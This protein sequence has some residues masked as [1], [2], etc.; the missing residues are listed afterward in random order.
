MARTGGEKTRCSGMWTEAKFKSFIKGNLR[1]TTMK[2]APISQCL[3]EARVERGLYLCAG[4]KEH[5]PATVKEGRV[6]KKFVHVDHIEPIIDPEE[7]WVSWDETIDSMFCELDNLQ[8]LCT[9]CHDE[10]TSREKEVAKQR[11]KEESS[12]SDRLKGYSRHVE[13]EDKQLRN[14]N[15]LQTLRNIHQDIGFSFA[16]NYLNSIPKDDQKDVL[17]LLITVAK[18]V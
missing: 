17:A 8:V 3:A 6:R 4:C 7:G 16:Q 14:Y 12:M 11:R 2:W 9:P 10:K 5:V 18:G 1:R 15:Q 13:T